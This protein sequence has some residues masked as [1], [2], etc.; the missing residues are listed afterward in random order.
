[1]ESFTRIVTSLDQ[2]LTPAGIL[3]V[4]PSLGYCLSLLQRL[5]ISSTETQTIA[6]QN[7]ATSSLRDHALLPG[8]FPCPSGLASMVG[9]S[10]G[11]QSATSAVIRMLRP[12]TD[13]LSSSLSP[14]T[15]Q[16]QS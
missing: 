7:L 12:L 13:P 2:V 10:C 11:A 8:S 16:E 14:S 1:M 3:S 5:G 6:L 15:G 9:G 4:K